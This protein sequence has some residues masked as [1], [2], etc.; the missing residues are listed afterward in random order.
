MTT[1]RSVAPEDEPTWKTLYSG[2]RDFYRLPSDQDVV[3]RVW[4]WLLDDAVPVVGLVAVDELGTVVG[5]ANTRAFHRPSS[6]TIG[7]YLDD[8]FVHPDHRGTGTG[9]ALLRHIAGDAHASGR[10]IVRWIT[11][12][13][14][15]TARRLYDSVS[16]GTRWVT[17][18][19]TPEP[20]GRS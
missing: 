20:D 3:D 13:D 14:N 17:Y 9:R 11:A 18:D 5:L 19:M 8:L 2:Y 7:T 6:G 4:A 12:E 1:V 15:W 16:T 10:S